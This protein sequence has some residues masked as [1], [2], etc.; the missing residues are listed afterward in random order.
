VSATG[1]AG[2]GGATPGKPVGLVHFGLAQNGRPVMS[3]AQI[4]P[5]DRAEVRRAAVLYALSL[6]ETAAKG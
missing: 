4:F 1:I 5:G 2:P 6:L 3:H